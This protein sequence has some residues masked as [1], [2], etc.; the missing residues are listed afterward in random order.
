FPGS[1]DAFDFGLAA[2]FSFGADLAA[3]TVHFGS[4]CAELVHHRI[5]S[6]GGALEVTFQF[7][8]V[9]FHGHALRKVA[10][11]NGA[12]DTSGFADGMGKTIDQ[13]IDGFDALRP[14]AGRMAD[15]HA[16]L[17][18]AFFANDSADP[19]QLLSGM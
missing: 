17:N 11:G 1:G 8:A 13:G 4:K 14:F 7:A 9:D 10:L 15:R 3:D 16:F 18:A 19:A 5:D 12:N 2:Q 6:L